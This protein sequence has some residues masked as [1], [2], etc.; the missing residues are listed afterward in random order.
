MPPGSNYLTTFTPD[1]IARVEARLWPRLDVGDCWLWT[2][3][4]TQRFHRP[5]INIAGTPRFVYRV[6]WE[7][8]VGPCPQDL[9]PDHLCKAPLCANTDHLEWVTHEVNMRRSTVHL[10][11]RQRMTDTCP[12]GHAY[13]GY[14]DGQRRCSEC[15]RLRHARDRENLTPAQIE[16]QRA[17]QRAYYQRHKA[18]AKT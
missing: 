17:Y 5:V 2:G 7:L 12:A 1:Q 13:D 10:L 4:P 8:L 3:K 14:R 15:E 6:V 11:R 9:E 18:Q 16:A